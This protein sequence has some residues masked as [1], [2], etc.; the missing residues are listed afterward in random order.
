MATPPPAAT[1]PPAA[2][3]PPLFSHHSFGWFLLLWLFLVTVLDVSCCG[4]SRSASAV[5]AGS[6]MTRNTMTIVVVDV[7]VIVIVSWFP[8]VASW[9]LWPMSCGCGWLL[10]VHRVCHFLWLR[11]DCCSCCISQLWLVFP[12]VLSFPL[13]VCGWLLQLFVIPHGCVIVYHGCIMVVAIVASHHCGWLLQLPPLS[14]LL[15]WL[16]VLVL[17]V[18][19]DDCCCCSC[20]CPYFPLFHGCFPHPCSCVQFGS[21]ATCF[22]SH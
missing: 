17:V 18:V 16:L 3:M 22:Q 11:R 12:F 4:H 13:V 14:W 8:A 21:L 2:M 20:F 19:V 15:L 6:E 9:L 7:A 1:L 10:R 5:A